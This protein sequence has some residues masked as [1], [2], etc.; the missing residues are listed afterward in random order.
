MAGSESQAEVFLPLTIT[1][2]LRGKEAS[3]SGGLATMSWLPIRVKPRAL[4]AYLGFRLRTAA[5]RTAANII[6]KVRSCELGGAKRKTQ[7]KGRFFKGTA[8]R[9][10]GAPFPFPSRCSKNLEQRVNATPPLPLLPGAFCAIPSW[11]SAPWGLKNGSF[12]ACG[13]RAVLPSL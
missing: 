7:G 6:G 5:E 8:K 10:L 4:I 12:H 9:G 2:W 11:A 13:I 1:W 3:V